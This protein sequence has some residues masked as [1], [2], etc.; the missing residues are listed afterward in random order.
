[1]GHRAKQIYQKMKEKQF[2][3][4]KTSLAHKNV[5]IKTTLILHL[6]PVRMAKIKYTNDNIGWHE[7]REK[8]TLIH[9]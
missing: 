6:I 1:M 4:K 9:C 5:L 2:R 7:Y 3:L 8:Q